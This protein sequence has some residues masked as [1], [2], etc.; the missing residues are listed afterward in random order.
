MA[1]VRAEEHRRRRRGRTPD[2]HCR[3]PPRRNR[4]ATASSPVPP[5]ARPR[6]A[7]KWPPASP[8]SATSST[9]A[10]ARTTSS[11]ARKLWFLIAGVAVA[12]VHPDPGRQGR[13]QLRHR[14]PRRL[15]IHGLQ[16]QDHRRRARREGR[17]DVVRRGRAARGQRRRHHHA[18]PDGPAHRRR[19]APVKKAL[20]EAYGVTDNEVT[21]SFI[22]PTWGADVT[23]QALMG[24]AIFVGLAA[25][26]MALYFRTWKMSLAAIVGMLGDLFITTGVYAPQRLRNHAVGDHRLP[27]DPQLLAVRHRRGVRQDPREHRGH[28]GLHPADL[29][30]GGQPRGQPDP[31]PV[32]QHHGGGHPAGRRDPL[33][34][35]RAAR[36]PDTLRDISLALFVG[37]LIGTAR[38]DLHRR[39]AVR[40]A[41]R[42]ANPT[43]SSRPNGWNRGVLTRQPRP[44]RRRR[45]PPPEPSQ[46][47]RTGR[48]P[49]F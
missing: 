44:S 8:T 15:A 31:G 9:R 7:S 46:R 34:R 17:Q 47:P 24:L 38:H 13:L 2:D 4:Q 5:R 11:A 14:V 32:D 49:S 18:G 1:A 45:P 25:V 35:R 19:D 27:D 12:L 48:R 23:R 41:A 22:G 33:H 29:R 16:R 21:S 20:T 40:R 36:V 42:R 39:A 37:I 10:S 26:L 6:R 28:A 30:R 43:W 3:T